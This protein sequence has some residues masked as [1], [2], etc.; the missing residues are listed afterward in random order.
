MALTILSAVLVQALTAAVCWY[1]FPPAEAAD[2]RTIRI[3]LLGHLAE[4]DGLPLAGVDALERHLPRAGA[5][6]AHRYRHHR[7]QRNPAE[8]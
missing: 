4:Q 2:A 5:L 3:P 1:G 8:L 7:R 6:R